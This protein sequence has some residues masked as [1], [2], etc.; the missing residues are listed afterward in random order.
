MVIHASLLFIQSAVVLT[1]VNPHPIKKVNN[2]ILLIVPIVDMVIQLLIC[3]ICL[4]VGTSSQIRNFDCIMVEDGQGGYSLSLKLRSSVPEQI[5]V[6]L[7]TSNNYESLSEDLESQDSVRNSFTQQ[8]SLWLNRGRGMTLENR[9]GCDE[10]MHQF[11]QY[12][13]DD[14][15]ISEI[16]PKSHYSLN[17]IDV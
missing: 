9:K 5:G 3:H 15:I 6:P 17:L 4:T 16:N 14:S 1:L 12:S 11:L 13:F 8:D 7:A 10:I 2:T